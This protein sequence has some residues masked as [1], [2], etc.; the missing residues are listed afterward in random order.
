MLEGL[1]IDQALLLHQVQKRGFD[2]LALV[3]GNGGQLRIVV[4]TGRRRPA[5][6]VSSLAGGGGGPF[7]EEVAV[8]AASFAAVFSMRLT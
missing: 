5:K 7:V 3:R 2:Q 6:G 4:R 1:L 8:V